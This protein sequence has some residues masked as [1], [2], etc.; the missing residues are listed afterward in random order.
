[1]LVVNVRRSAVGRRMLAVRANERAAA[2]GG[3]NVPRTKLLGAALGSF[4]ASVAGVMMGYKFVDFS[5]AGFEASRG[6]AVVALAYIGGIA[7]V[8]GAFVAGI[9]AP[10]ASS[11]R[12]M[13]ANSTDA[14]AAAVGLR[15]DHRGHQV[16][17]RHRQRHASRC[18]GRCNGPRRT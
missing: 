6:L 13:G 10:P 5:N 7:T 11:S 8:G 2:A 14:A 12:S 4:L 16:P 18:G 1:M 15:P 17:R 3:I 9:L